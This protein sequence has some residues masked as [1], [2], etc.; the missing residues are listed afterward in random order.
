[1][2]SPLATRR[3]SMAQ[4]ETR[5]VTLLFRSNP[6]H[7][8]DGLRC[9]EV[10]VVNGVIY[11]GRP[12]SADGSYTE[13]NQATGEAPS[14]TI[15]VSRGWRMLNAASCSPTRPQKR[16]S[17]RSI[18]R[19]RTTKGAWQGSRTKRS[20]DAQSDDRY[21]ICHL[22]ATA[23]LPPPN[24]PAPSSPFKPQEGSYGASKPKQLTSPTPQ[25]DRIC[26]ALMKGTAD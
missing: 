17:A 25:Q 5:R 3:R 13:G 16:P 21:L 26:M 8:R 9:A 22:E 4:S 24:T 23:P 20:R 11:C 1:M 14:T 15:Y 18:L 19:P 2:A 12:H 7:L 6:H 10:L